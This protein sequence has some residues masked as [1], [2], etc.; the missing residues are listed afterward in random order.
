MSP[1][2]FE[3]D[4]TKTRDLPPGLA[5]VTEAEV[6]SVPASPVTPADERETAVR[7]RLPPVFATG[8]RLFGTYELIEMLGEGGMGLVF[9]A[10]DLNLGREVA[11]KMLRTGPFADPVEVQR[12]YNEA[13]SAARLDHANIVPIYDVDQEQGQHFYTMR[14][15]PGGSLSKLR[16]RYRADARAT[17]AVVEKVARAVHFAHQNGI[18]HRDLKPGNILIDE[19]GEPHVADFG[20]AKVLGG[21][22]DLTEPGVQLGTPVYMAPEQ[23]AGKTEVTP[24]SDIWSLGVILYELLT[25]SR[26]FDGKSRDEVM[27][28]VQ[29]E[30]PEPPSRLEPRLGRDLQTICLKCL[31]KNP[32]QRYHSAEELADDLRRWLQGEPI[33][34]R[35]AGW[36][37][38]LWRKVKKHRIVAA[39]LLFAALVTAAVVVYD[40]YT[41]PDRVAKVYLKRLARGEAV[42]L[43]GDTG[44]PLWYRWATRDRGTVRLLDKHEPVLQV[45]TG[46]L[47]LLELLPKPPGPYYR[48]SAELQHNSGSSTGGQMGKVGLY[49][50][51]ESF[52]TPN[53]KLHHFCYLRFSESERERWGGKNPPRSRA[54]VDLCR[55]HE[56]NVGT[57]AHGTFGLEVQ[58]F[59]EPPLPFPPKPAKWRTLMLEVRPGGVWAFWD[60]N[61]LP[62]FV[63]DHHAQE[64]TASFHRDTALAGEEPPDFRLEGALGVYAY[65]AGVAVRRVVVEPI[66][67]QQ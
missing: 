59:F 5:P 48:V 50:F 29:T 22:I 14:L 49:F 6:S 64:F 12:F 27:S 63:G 7:R 11:L 53:G 30:E 54:G 8:S 57:N 62:S 10:R 4:V 25:G 52:D 35:P 36:G 56:R 41:D 3:S 67:A 34:A 65:G 47:G 28:R 45:E 13:R 18:L 51:H 32:A 15:V 39:G 1:R 21:G 26:P 23:A 20:L 61:P 37:E 17:V 31:R 60:G 44:M 43:V 38:R 55:Y 46:S 42:T 40:R 33:L 16:E 9:R 19:Q 2:A 24:A 66:P 58:A